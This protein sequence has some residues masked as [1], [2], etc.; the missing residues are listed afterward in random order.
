MLYALSSVS[1]SVFDGR[2][3]PSGILL[4]SIS[5]VFSSCF[6]FLLQHCPTTECD[7]HL[8]SPRLQSLF[9][10]YFTTSSMFTGH[11]DLPWFAIHLFAWM[12]PSFSSQVRCLC[13]IGSFFS[14]SHKRFRVSWR[15]SWTAK[16]GNLSSTIIGFW[17][18]MNGRSLCTVQIEDGR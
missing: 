10:C 8:A 12:T 18:V 7:G 2:Q 4:S 16:S 1:L 11:D 5:S 6:F 17:A 13:T 15:M 3:W 14:L 9:I